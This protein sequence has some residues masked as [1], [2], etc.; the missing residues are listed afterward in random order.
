MKYWDSKHV[1]AFPKKR[2][3]GLWE[4]VADPKYATG[5]GLVLYGLD[6]KMMRTVTQD[7]GT[8]RL[9]GAASYSGKE[10]LLLGTDRRTHEG[11]VR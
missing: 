2:G 1:L 4:E 5:V 10:Q 6:P 9:S 11:L 3:S 8:R 7:D